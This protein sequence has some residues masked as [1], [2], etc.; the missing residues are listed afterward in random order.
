MTPVWGRKRRRRPAAAGTGRS[1]SRTA[2]PAASSTSPS[3]PTV[4][5][6]KWSAP[7]HASRTLGQQPVS[8][9]AA[10]PG[11]G[12]D[13]GA[14]GNGARSPSTSF[15]MV[16]PLAS[17]MR[18]RYDVGRPADI[19][20]VHQLTQRSGN[21]LRLT[22]IPVLAL[23]KSHG[24]HHVAVLVTLEGTSAVGRTCF[25]GALSCLSTT[26]ASHAA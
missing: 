15:A 17:A 24:R 3:R 19:G 5:T 26:S 9:G 22:P 4:A 10:S 12:R 25:L 16:G 13:V 6:S 14:L 1:S 20:G 8:P 2:V 23:G 21:S 11:P 7:D 18:R